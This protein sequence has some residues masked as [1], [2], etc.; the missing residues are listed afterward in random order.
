MRV[1]MGWGKLNGE[2]IGDG[3]NIEKPMQTSE[4]VPSATGLE[5]EAL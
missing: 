5:I 4:N 1:A 2:A 3:K